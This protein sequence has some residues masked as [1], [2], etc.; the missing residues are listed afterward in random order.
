MSQAK[1]KKARKRVPI[2]CLNC[3]KRKV[4]CNKERPCAGCVKNNVA[5]LCVYVEPVWAESLSFMAVDG[6]A[7]SDA[8]QKPQAAASLPSA[9][10]TISKQAAELKCLRA[11]LAHLSAG[12]PGGA[13]TLEAVKRLAVAPIVVQDLQQRLWQTLQRNHTVISVLTR[14]NPS[15]DKK[16]A[17]VVFGDNYFELSN[18]GN[19]SAPKNA[20]QPSPLGLYSWLNIIRLDAQL[21]GLWYKITS[22]QKSYYLYKQSLLKQSSHSA[23]SATSGNSSDSPTCSH[24]TCP[25]VACEFNTM[26][27]ESEILARREPSRSASP[28][29]TKSSG[30]VFDGSA[31]IEMLEQLQKMWR[32]V[33]NHAA[34]ARPLNFAQLDFLVQL[35]F[36]KV[37]SC[38]YKQACQ[39]SDVESRNLLQPFERHIRNTFHCV[40]DELCL[41]VGVLA[42]DVLDDHMLKAIKTKAVYVSML[43][44]V[45]DEAIECV[46]SR[47]ALSDDTAATFQ[48]VFGADFFHPKNSSLALPMAENV[49]ILQRISLRDGGMVSTLLAYLSLLVA[50]LNCLL[51]RYDRLEY[52]LEIRD[53]FTQVF[54]IL[55]ES[56]GTDLHCLELWCDPAQICYDSDTQDEVSKIRLLFCQLWSDI[57]RIVNLATLNFMP[58]LKQ[59]RHLD[60]QV[61]LLLRT[62]VQAEQANTHVRFLDS[63]AAQS[64]N[65]RI[66]NPLN[67]LQVGYLISRATFV[68]LN[69]VYGNRVQ[70]RVTISELA[71][72]VS[73][74]SGW[75]DKI[76]H[77][78]LSPAKYF[79]LRLMLQVVELMLL[80]V[81]VYQGEELGDTELLSNVI[82]VL[83]SKCLDINKFLQG[84]CG[85]FAKTRHASPVLV[86][87]AEALAR[88]SHLIAGLLIRFSAEKNVRKGAPAKDAPA[89][90]VYEPKLG[91]ASWITISAETKDNLIRET[92]S[93]MV[94]LDK[95]A[96]IDD[97]AK[98]T[99]IWR[100]YSTF[101]RTSHR[102]N[103]ESYAKLHAEAFKSQ[104]LLSMCPV[105]PR[106]KYPVSATRTGVGACPVLH[107]GLAGSMDFRDA[108]SVTPPLTH[109]LSP[110]GLEPAKTWLRPVTHA[111]SSSLTSSP[112]R[113]LPSAPA[114]LPA[115]KL[116]TTEAAPDSKLCETLPAAC[117]TGANSKKRRYLESQDASG[118]FEDAYKPELKYA[119]FVQRYAPALYA[120]AT[121]SSASQPPTVPHT[122]TGSKQEQLDI[123]D[124]D[125]LPNFDFAF[126]EDES[127][128]MQVNKSDINGL[129]TE[130]M[131]L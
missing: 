88:I 52:S 90:L 108:K 38:P 20:A 111:D 32:K 45:V 36:N 94:L 113:L 14:L 61:L 64:L 48:S 7:S 109:F 31:A 13:P 18:F 59:S 93:T 123:I 98:N 23:A 58:V 117:S 9:E 129:F 122:P 76:S 121:P 96:T 47:S 15:R 102:I 72:L 42:S 119:P 112:L 3:K 44:I 71:V 101:I 91:A 65:D 56:I 82:P 120:C 84:S 107:G 83:F 50:M 86:I 105:M 6:L 127:L 29:S 19:M 69:G 70:S 95:N 4:K 11:Q 97:M 115:S 57:V 116:T 75:V 100:F 126:M 24:R 131:F 106:F 2:S 21:S 92:D 25:V 62:I 33:K 39:A 63:L 41:N 74:L 118:G 5:H 125:S 34:V 104:K 81:I 78:T 28:P 128:M 16:S 53:A 55:F 73:Q 124:W 87:I 54:E 114:I 8:L 30:P 37:G 99:K 103:S 43:S 60:A 68:L 85:Q 26:L 77:T 22:L 35:Y 1:E 80:A 12:K 89:V 110:G 49:E 51:N 67:A 17:P 10:A 46:V 27:E 66:C 40:D 130:S 79:E